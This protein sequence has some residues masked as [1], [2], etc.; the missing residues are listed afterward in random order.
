MSEGTVLAAVVYHEGENIDAL[1]SGMLQLLT[2]KGVK[3]GGLIQAPCDE[4][5]MATHIESGRKI[6]LMQDLGVCADGC[7]LDTAA[8]AE[9]A[10]LL[11][12][13]LEAEP[14]L[15]LVSRFGRAEREGGGFLAEIGLAASREIPT[16][17]GVAARRRAEWEAFA[18]EYS[19]ILPCDLD[20]A[21]SWWE[22]IGKP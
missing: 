17:I 15:L 14:H 10:G 19:E 9:A 16:L 4:T 1:M 7:R 22:R 21:L 12:Q 13:G 5:V 11:A 18:G 20:A 2:A 6:D 8:L 3:V